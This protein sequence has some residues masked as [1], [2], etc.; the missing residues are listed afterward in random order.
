MPSSCIKHVEI[1]PWA[2]V[3]DRYTYRN[4]EK[5][6]FLINPYNSFQIRKWNGW[7]GTSKNLRAKLGTE[8]LLCCSKK[9]KLTDGEP[10]L[11]ISHCSPYWYLQLKRWYREPVPRYNP[12]LIHITLSVEFHS[13][14]LAAAKMYSGQR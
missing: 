2:F 6:L 3:K 8:N 7:L 12:P 10:V 4:W 14:I 5:A 11:R 13:L 9:G 1:P